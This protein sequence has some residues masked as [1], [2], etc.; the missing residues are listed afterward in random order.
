MTKKILLQTTIPTMED[1]W[2]IARFSCLGALLGGQRAA[3]GNPLYAVTM[4]DRDPQ[5]PATGE[6]TGGNL[7]RRPPAGMRAGRPRSRVGYSV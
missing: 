7:D 5:G 4:R 3:S 2:S 6:I 1:D